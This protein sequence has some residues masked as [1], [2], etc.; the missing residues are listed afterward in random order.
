MITWTEEML[1]HYGIK[2][3]KKGRRRY[4]NPDGSLTPAGK[5]R[6][7]D[8]KANS[9]RGSYIHVQDSSKSAPSGSSAKTQGAKN[10]IGKTSSISVKKT[11][12]S[13]SEK[14]T[15]VQNAG[16]KESYEVRVDKKAGTV[17]FTIN[18]KDGTHTAY[19]YNGKNNAVYK[20]E[21][22]KAGRPLSGVRPLSVTDPEYKTYAI[23]G[24][25]ALG[26]T[27]EITNGEKQLTK[28]KAR[29][30]TKVDSKPGSRKEQLK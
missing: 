19:S 27:G 12:S 10:V 17:S 29:Q 26:N 22:D 7:L 1:M 18:R 9:V 30:S 3:Q 24:Q 23:K 8:R 16:R 14:P 15:S 11:N 21:Y 4:Q 2:G 20:Q 28:E 25:K 5:L 13:N 6:Y